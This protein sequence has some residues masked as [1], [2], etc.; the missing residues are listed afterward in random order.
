MSSSTLIELF[1]HI[2]VSFTRGV[3]EHYN[4]E[5]PEFTAESFGY[6]PLQS[7]GREW[8]Y[9]PVDEFI[10]QE[11]S[12]RGDTGY[13]YLPS[14]NL[15]V[16]LINACSPEE[17]E[18]TDHN[19]QDEDREMG[20]KRFRP[21]AVHTV[22]KSMCIGA[23]ISLLT[24]TIIGSLF[25]FF[26]YLC[27]KTVLNCLFH[28]KDTIPVQI[29]WISSISAIISCAFLYIWFFVSILFLFR[30]YQLMGV[31][32]KLVLVSFLVY[33]LDALYRVTLQALDIS[34]NKAFTL[35][36]I[37]LNVLFFTSV[38]VQVY[39]VTTHFSVGRSGR[40]RATLFVQL[41]LPSSFSYVL[42]LIALFFIY[43][44]YNKQNKEGKLLIAIFAPLIGVVLK[45]ISRISVQRLWN[46]TH[47]GYS[48]VL[49]AP[50][51]FGSAVMFRVLQA[52]L[53]SLQSMAILGIIHGA[54]EVIERSIMVVIDHICHVIWKRTS[55]PWGSF[56]TPR[57]ER[58]MTDI[59]IMSML[60]EST[61]IVSVNGVLYLYQFIYLPNKSFVKL[62][63]SFAIHTSVLLVIEWFFTS[64]S[65]AIETRFQNM[66]VM[67]VWRKRWKR[68]LLVAIVNAVPLALWLSAYLIEILHGRFNENNQPCRMPFT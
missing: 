4:P 52:D 27:Y 56:R 29:Q 25:M 65:L 57:R 51:Y 61:G 35:L 41:I 24:A 5:E 16:R 53:N 43:P 50:V 46:V 10:Y 60:Y 68:H 17:N 14:R 6:D 32:R 54:A 62:L 36:T 3:T 13:S 44:A 28:S 30:P 18:Q 34:S 11:Y 66:A 22:C 23:L 47:P 7:T 8:N 63:Q 20:W 58:L 31:K 1:G 45:V 38:C 21:S 40:Q 9:R 26:T 42:T 67:A 49:L 2:L 55:A 48:Y 64:V 19:Q 12:D 39:L 59:A 37:P 33:C 15:D